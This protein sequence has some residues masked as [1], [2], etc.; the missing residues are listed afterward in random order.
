MVFLIAAAGGN[1]AKWSVHENFCFFNATFYI[2]IAYRHFNKLQRTLGKTDKIRSG[3]CG[4]PIR[5][6]TI[7]ATH[8][9]AAITPWAHMFFKKQK[10]VPPPNIYYTNRL[11]KYVLEILWFNTNSLDYDEYQ[12]KFL[13]FPNKKNCF[14]LHEAMRLEPN[15]TIISHSLFENNLSVWIW[16][17]AIKMDTNFTIR[18]LFPSHTKPNFFTIRCG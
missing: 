2:A 17:G 8:T 12:T 15:H 14:T 1:N 4:E 13:C 18:Y 5:L 10:R 16:I 3:E 11:A 6:I 9:K 7:P